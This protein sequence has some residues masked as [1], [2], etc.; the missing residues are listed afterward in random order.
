MEFDKGMKKYEEIEQV[1]ISNLSPSDKMINVQQ[2]FPSDDKDK[3]EIDRLFLFCWW[4]F[5]LI[6]STKLFLENYESF[7]ESIYGSADYL[8]KIQTTFL[9]LC[10]KKIRKDTSEIKTLYE[11][12]KKDGNSEILTHLLPWSNQVRVTLKYG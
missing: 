8:K 7:I 12:S 5:K 9:D 11:K 4:N 3:A 10:L 6:F 2:L 1:L